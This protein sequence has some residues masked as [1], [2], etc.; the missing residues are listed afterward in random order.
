MSEYGQIDVTLENGVFIIEIGGLNAA[1]HRGLARVFRDAHDAEDARIVVL[2]GKNRSFLTPG[3]YD[4]EYIKASAEPANL[5]MRWGRVPT[6]IP[7]SSTS[8][9]TESLSI[10]PAKTIGSPP[11]TLQRSLEDQIKAGR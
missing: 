9:V 2:T 5:R 10:G 6:P 4:L 8:Q 3:M 7:R 11:E 1:T